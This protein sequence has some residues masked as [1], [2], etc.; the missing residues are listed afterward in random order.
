MFRLIRPTLIICDRVKDKAN[1]LTGGVRKVFG[2]LLSFGIKG[3]YHSVEESG[4]INTPIMYSLFSDETPKITLLD[5]IKEF[6]FG[7]EVEKGPAIEDFSIDPYEGEYIDEKFGKIS[8][9]MKEL[10]DGGF[11]EFLI[12]HVALEEQAEKDLEKGEK[13][14]RI[15]DEEQEDIVRNVELN[16]DEVARSITTRSSQNP[17]KSFA[18]DDTAVDSQKDTTNIA[19]EGGKETPA[20]SKTEEQELIDGKTSEAGS[21]NKAGQYTDNGK[22]SDSKTA[23][24]EVNKE[25]EGSTTSSVELSG[26]TEISDQ[27][28]PVKT[29]STRTEDKLVSE[30]VVDGKVVEQLVG[31]SII[32]QKSEAMEVDIEKEDK[33]KEQ[34]VEEETLSDKELREA[35][36]AAKAASTISNLGDKEKKKKSV[37]N[38]SKNKKKKVEMPG[39]WRNFILG[40]KTVAFDYEQHQDM[41]EAP[42]SNVWPKAQGT[43]VDYASLRSMNNRALM[44]YHDEFQDVLE[45]YAKQRDGIIN[46]HTSRIL[47]E[48]ARRKEIEGL[49]DESGWL[50]TGW[51]RGAKRTWEKVK[52]RYF[53][54]IVFYTEHEGVD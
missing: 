28:R 27:A 17:A 24:V 40:G 2:K 29:D 1:S 25:L 12:D 52:E 23:V 42:R 36:E 49:A 46:M 41:H 15:E 54:D 4:L 21:D 11:E 45:W 26:E 44:A 20:T 34:L 32:D 47:I 37:P 22:V 30:E 35:A 19:T 38:T 51:E 18:N 5:Q 39:Y 31:V 53:R 8:L 16:K 43:L 7:R 9:E 6:I 50:P 13:V 3:T 33:K 48:Q 14:F 10:I